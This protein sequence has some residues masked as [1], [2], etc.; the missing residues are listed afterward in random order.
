MDALVEYFSEMPSSHR[1]AVLL[2]G[3]TLFL[4][5]ENAVPF[6]TSK[7]NKWRHTG[8]NIFFTATTVLINF[9]MAFMLL[10]AASLVDRSGFGIIQWI[11]I[12]GIWFLLIGLMLLDF[13]GAF[14]PHY[15]EHRIR[16]LWQFH[17]IHHTDQN[18]DTTTANR[19][20]PGESV[21]RFLFTL[22]A[23]II[24]GAPMWM[25]FMYQSLS[26]VLSQFNH[27]NVKMPEWL[28]NAL[29]WIF[30]TPNMH[31]VHHHY[32]QPY[33]D[34]NYGNIFSLW[35]RA[36][37]T[38]VKVDNAQLIYGVDTHMDTKEAN[39]II[40]LLKIP[41]LRYRGSIPYE[42]EENLEG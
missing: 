8:I 17:L 31:R 20:H 15:I 9:A 29:V 35:D 26:V 30:C 2:G 5:I 11:P 28:D 12:Q 21:L 36:F 33:S 23:V 13:I 34:K 40:T 27:S 38:Y 19:H 22:I 7:Y 39:D 25:V 18:V 32:R 37:G 10:W 1:S 14:L 41:F 42:Q 16:F 24:V 6:F 3:L 4:M